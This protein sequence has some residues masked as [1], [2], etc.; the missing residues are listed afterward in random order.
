M[1]RESRIDPVAFKAAESRQGV[2]HPVLGVFSRHAETI[3]RLNGEFTAIRSTESGEVAFRKEREKLADYT[4]LA[5][6]FSAIDAHT[7]EPLDLV[8]LWSGIAE[9]FPVAPIRY[10][11]AQSLVL[12]YAIQGLENPQWKQLPE[13]CFTKDDASLYD[14]L[15]QSDMQGAHQVTERIKEVRANLRALV[16]FSYGYQLEPGESLTEK[17]GRLRRQLKIDPDNVQVLKEMHHLEEIDEIKERDYA[18]IYPIVDGF[19]RGLDNFLREDL[20]VSPDSSSTPSEGS[21]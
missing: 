19:Q 7:L 18:I 1:E 14:E 15:C 9:T 5:E 2:S 12:T 10:A 16:D 13:T 20:A 11:V 4:F 6:E 3:S 17:Y 21:S 8:A